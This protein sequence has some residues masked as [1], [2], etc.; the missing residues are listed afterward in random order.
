MSLL[1]SLFKTKK[2][3]SYEGMT[4]RSSLLESTGGPQYYQTI[5]DR[6]AGRGVGFGDN[7]A[8]KYANPIIQNSRA[9]FT[10]YQL[11]ELKSELS[12]SGRRGATGGNDLLRRAYNDQG[13]QENDIFSRLQQRNEDQ[14]RSEINNAFD[15]LG[16]FN[17]DE[18]NV[19]NNAANFNYNTYKGEVQN[20][21]NDYAANQNT[22][23]NLVATAGSVIAAPFTGGA[24]LAGIGGGGF[25]QPM[26]NGYYPSAPPQGY[27]LSN[28]QSRLASRN[29]QLGRIR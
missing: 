3:P 7:Y 9:N 25:N 22:A 16:S 10:D 19:W 1:S 28:I 12:V 6:L 8:S 21:N 5:Q 15:K 18:N 14:S 23:K 17:Q 24:S 20:L 11:P 29:G 4:P 27:D 2:T 26:A 13:L